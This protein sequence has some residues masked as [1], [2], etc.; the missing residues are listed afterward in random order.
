MVYSYNE[1][2]LA[3]GKKKKKRTTETWTKWTNFKNITQSKA[4]S[5][6]QE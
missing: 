3:Q 4:R 6:T 5:K 1:I 2:V